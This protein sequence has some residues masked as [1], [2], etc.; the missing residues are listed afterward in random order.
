MVIIMAIMIKIINKIKDLK[1]VFDFNIICLTFL[2]SY[3]FIKALAIKPGYKG[4]L[5]HLYIIESKG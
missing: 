4:N 1:C 5:K 2:F 3:F